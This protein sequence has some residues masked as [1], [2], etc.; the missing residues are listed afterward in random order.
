MGERKDELVDGR[1]PSIKAKKINSI[2]HLPYKTG[3]DIKLNS[4]LV[5]RLLVVFFFTTSGGAE[6][7]C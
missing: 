6:L 3:G 1:L 5:F 2:T 7:R 4:F